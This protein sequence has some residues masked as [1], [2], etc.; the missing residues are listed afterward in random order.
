MRTFIGHKISVGTKTLG[1]VKGLMVNELKD[2]IFIQGDDKR[3]TRIFKSDIGAYVPLDYEPFDYV[4]FHVLFCQ[5]KRMECPG[6]QYISAGEGFTHKDIELFVSPC[7][8]RAED[9]KMG[10]K[11]ELRS[12]SGKFLKAMLAGTMFGNYPEKGRKAKNGN[13]GQRT[14]TVAAAPECETGSGESGEGEEQDNGGI[15]RATEAA[16]RP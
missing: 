9:C 11:G 10:T 8:C 6:V 15:G 3:I 14:G 5:N 4:P 7:P 13:T 16:P 1:V 12:V 2:R